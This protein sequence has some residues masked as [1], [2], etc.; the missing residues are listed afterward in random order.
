MAAE[1]VNKR[2]G[3]VRGEA[4]GKCKKKAEKG[5]IRAGARGEN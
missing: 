1:E 2:E 3:E 4:S 5:M